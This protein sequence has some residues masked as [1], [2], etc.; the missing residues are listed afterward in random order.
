[1]SDTRQFRN[2]TER[3][4]WVSLYAASVAC[5]GSLSSVNHEEQA[6][7]MLNDMRSRMV[8]LDE[9]VT[10]SSPQS[11]IEKLAARALST[12]DTEQVKKLAATGIFRPEQMLILTE[13]AQLIAARAP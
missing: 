3:A 10:P 7:R 12:I 2:Q 11:D 1:M 8:V 6:D 9:V 4:A 13:L 5:D